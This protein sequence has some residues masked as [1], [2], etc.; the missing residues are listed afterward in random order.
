VVPARRHIFAHADKNGDLDPNGSNMPILVGTTN[1]QIVP[2]K[3][4]KPTFRTPCKYIMV[5]EI[6]VNLS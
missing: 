2:E 3:E 5:G 4:V 6:P 1:V